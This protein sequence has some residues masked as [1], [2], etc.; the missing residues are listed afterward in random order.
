MFL[1]MGRSGKSVT[2]WRRFKYQIDTWVNGEE[3][4]YVVAPF[5]G[6]LLDVGDD[7]IPAPDFLREEMREE[8]EGMWRKLEGRMPFQST[9]E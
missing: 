3:S 8:V 9:G 1:W 2:L 7:R 4:K 5:E 6:L